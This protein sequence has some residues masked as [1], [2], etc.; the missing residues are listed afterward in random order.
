M[1]KEQIYPE[2]R[3]GRE[4]MCQ[5][6]QECA[7][8]MCVLVAMIPRVGSRKPKNDVLSFFKRTEQPMTAPIL[9]HPFRRCETMIIRLPALTQV[10]SFRR[11]YIRSISC[12]GG[13]LLRKPHVKFD[14]DFKNGLILTYRKDMVSRSG[15]LESATKNFIQTRS[16]LSRRAIDS[17]GKVD[18]FARGLHIASVM[19]WN[20]RD[21]LNSEFGSHDSLATKKELVDPATEFASREAEL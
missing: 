14:C 6:K 19:T 2:R 11:M 9:K 15:N 7:W 18:I 17:R 3:S 20:M 4:R 13:I 1:Y 10:S 21:G 5:A 8:H 12:P 16:L